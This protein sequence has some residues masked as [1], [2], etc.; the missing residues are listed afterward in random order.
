MKKNKEKFGL[1]FLL[2][3]A[4]LFSSQLTLAQNSKEKVSESYDVEDGVEISLDARQTEIV[5]ETWNRNSVEIEASLSGEELN[6]EE[7]DQLAEA[8]NVNIMGNSNQITIQ[9]SHH[10]IP[11]SHSGSISS[12]HRDFVAPLMKNMVGPMLEGISSAQLPPQFYEGMSQLNFDYEAYQ[13]EGEA[14]VER[15][16]KQIEKSFGKDFEV[17]MEKWGERFEKNAEAWA[18]QVEE[19]MKMLE[20]SG[21]LEK[22]QEEYAKRMEAWGKRMEQM[23]TRM[24]QGGGEVTKKVTTSPNGSKSVSVYY[25]NSGNSSPVNENDVRRKILIKMPKDAKLKFNLRHGSLTLEDP[26]ENLS[27]NLAY[28][29]FNADEIAGKQTAINV[30]YAPVAIKNWEYG[31]LN[32]S[33]VKECRINSIKSIKLNSNASDVVIE[34]IDETGIIS[35]VFGELSIASLGNNFKRLDINLE[36]SDLVLKLPET[37]F[38]FNYSGSRSN[39]NVPEKMSTTVSDSYGSKLINGFYKSR[40][41][42]KNIT[43]NAKFSEVMMQ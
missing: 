33:Y 7:L 29:A 26:A 12:L 37:S 4:L 42:D 20:E 25:R 21:E 30:A 23:A 38:N 3:F 5:V 19:R 1:T 16:E 40:N 22:R 15:Y 17:A 2:V 13:Q 18:K 9:S 10:R 43:I 36:N 24:A 11:N 34:S 28:T 32:L 31:A 41:T 8:W 6:D 39:V 35:G 27:G 14:Y